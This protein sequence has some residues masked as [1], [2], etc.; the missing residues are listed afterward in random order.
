M[1]VA[2]AVVAAMA[3]GVI[4]GGG[5]VEGGEALASAVPSAAMEDASAAP[6]A[7]AV[8]L[9]PGTVTA[10]GE[11]EPC[12]PVAKAPALP[13][14][15]PT[16][17]ALAR[18]KATNR[19][20]G[21]DAAQRTLALLLQAPPA[22]D[23]AQR[24]D[25]AAQVLASALASS[26]AATL[27]AAASVCPHVIDARGCRLQLIRR[28]IGLDPGNARP[29]VEWLDEDPTAADAAWAGLAAAIH[30]HD[31][32]QRLAA[33]VDRVLDPNLP[34]TLRAALLAEAAVH[35]ADWPAAAQSALQ[36]HCGHWGPQHPRGIAC[37]RGVALILS[38][39]NSPSTVPEAAALAR[40]TGWREEQL[41]VAEASTRRL[42][43]DASVD[44]E[45]GCLRR[46]GLHTDRPP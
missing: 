30:W 45:H 24:A 29:W 17:L 22:D 7:T 26:D 11:P 9:S 41:M 4:A 42:Q 12:E 3:V 35:D 44:V 2:V 38:D 40:G 1:G 34:P 27:R 20:A 5:G 6:A 10:D 33:A 32:P 21:G 14:P 25:W 18:Q 39:A 37:A 28:R 19:L 13:V 8:P 23:A 43:Q 31:E 36:N 46:A 16:A 15:D